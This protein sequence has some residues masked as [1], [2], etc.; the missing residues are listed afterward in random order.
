MLKTSRHTARVY[1]VV[2]SML[3][4]LQTITGATRADAGDFDDAMV[5]RADDAGEGGGGGK[6]F[7]ERRFMLKKPPKVPLI[8]DELGAAVRK[9]KEQSADNKP[10][11]EG[12]PGLLEACNPVPPLEGEFRHWLGPWNQSI[13][14]T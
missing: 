8:V 2:L 6:E 14:L 12:P 10:E 1:V 9:R 11:S 4:A 7:W 5:C 3:P 13:L